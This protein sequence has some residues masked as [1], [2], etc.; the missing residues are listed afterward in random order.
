[1]D[2]IEAFI[3]RGSNLDVPVREMPRIYRQLDAPIGKTD[4]IFLT[5]ARCRIPADLRGQF[6]GWK[7]AVKARLITL[8]IRSQPGDLAAI[9]DEAYV[10]PSLS[11]SEDAVGRV[12]SV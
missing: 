4:V 1:M 8:V 2:W 9:S 10:V 12:L 5:D 3:G 7:K 11:V 6:V